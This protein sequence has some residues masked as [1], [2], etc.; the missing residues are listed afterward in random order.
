M[1]LCRA[2]EMSEEVR[3]HR[4]TR[5]EADAFGGRQHDGGYFGVH[6]QHVRPKPYGAQVTRGGKR[7]RL[8][9]FVTAVV[10]KEE[11]SFDGRPKRQRMK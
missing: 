7:V 2:W 6:H 8:G 10:V 9:Y 3:Q 11:E 5:R 4:R 1:L